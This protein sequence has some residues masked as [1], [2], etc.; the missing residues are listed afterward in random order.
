MA[1]EKKAQ[2]KNGTGKNGTKCMIGK[3]GTILFLLKT[4]INKI[5]KLYILLTKKWKRAAKTPKGRPRARMTSPS[6]G[7]P[8]TVFAAMFLRARMT[9]PS[10]GSPNTVFAAMFLRARMTE[11]PLPRLQQRIEIPPRVLG[12]NSQ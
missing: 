10:D 5:F 9:S 3:N 8:N 11:D 2:G 12:R 6:D 1:Q 7:S 4:E